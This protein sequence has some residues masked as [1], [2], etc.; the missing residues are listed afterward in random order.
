MKGLVLSSLTGDRRSEIIQKLQGGQIK[1]II[2]T[3]SLEAG[4]DLPE[5]D[6]CLI[7]GFPGSLMSF[8][9]R[10]GRAGHK[11]HGLVIYL[12]LGQNP[13]DVYYARHNQK[14]LSGEVESAAFNPDYPTI[15]GKHLECG[16][17]ESSLTLG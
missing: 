11:Q 4:I 8:W 16:C 1:V 15:L 6:C 12:P 3:S 7:R 5:L 10:V 13:I 2:S 17:I 14:L 9:Q